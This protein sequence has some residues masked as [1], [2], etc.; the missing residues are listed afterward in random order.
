MP[1]YSYLCTDCAHEFDIQQSFA[2]E[3]LTVCPACGGV[4]RKVF[5]PVG[6]AFV[7]SGFY[8]TDSRDQPSGKLPVHKSS[9]KPSG[10]E[11]STGKDSSGQSKIPKPS[12]NPGG[13][14][15]GSSGSGSKDSGSGSK[16][17]RS[18]TS[19]TSNAQK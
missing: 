5:S 13:S 2:D 16:A 1:T 19:S 7:G 17:G 15:S 10:K 14:G 11:S 6:V 9:E 8:R 3:S 4:L 18:A 12:A